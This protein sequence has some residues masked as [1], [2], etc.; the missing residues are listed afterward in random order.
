MELSIIQ[1]Y[2]KIQTKKSKLNY[3]TLKI[4]YYYSKRHGIIQN[5][6]IYR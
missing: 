6:H 2:C 3:K 1:K 4:K 5:T